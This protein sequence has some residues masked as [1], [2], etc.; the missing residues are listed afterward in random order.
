MDK[1]F[2]RLSKIHVPS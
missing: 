2:P 1:M